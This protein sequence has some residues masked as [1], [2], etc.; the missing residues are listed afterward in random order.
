MGGGIVAM[1][2]CKPMTWT[3]VTKWKA[4]SG[5]GF[6]R[7]SE[8]PRCPQ[9]WSI[10]ADTLNMKVV[11]T[12]ED[13]GESVDRFF[14]SR[15][16]IEKRIRSRYLLLPHRREILEHGRPYSDA[17]INSS[18]WRDEQAPPAS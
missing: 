9:R 5:D 15:A 6:H 4:G 14:D 17:T 8:N 2:V 3:F 12:T 7:E 16:R 1:P 13:R 10:S 11:R 18:G